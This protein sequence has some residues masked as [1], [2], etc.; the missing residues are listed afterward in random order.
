MKVFDEV[1]VKGWKEDIDSLLVFAGL[2]SAVITAFIV[3]IY[4]Q[5]QPDPAQ[6]TVQ[7]LQQISFQL[8][9]QGASLN[10]TGQ[11]VLLSNAT[12]M[13]Y[14]VRISTVWLTALVF[15][16]ISALIGI[17]AK[18]WLREYLTGMSTSPR[19]AVRLRQYRHDGLVSWHVAEII[20]CLPIL[21][22]IA[23]VLFLYGLLELLWTLDGTVAGVVTVF[24]VLSLCFYLA[25]TVVP[26]FSPNNPFKSPQSW[27]FSVSM[28]R[29]GQLWTTF[30]PV[31]DPGIITGENLGAYQPIPGNW[32]ERELKYM[33][34]EGGE[35]EQRALA[36]AYKHSLDEDFLDIV[37]PCANDLEPAAA[38]ALAVEVLTRRAE[39]SESMLMESIRS[40]SHRLVV[41][42]FIARA[43]GRGTQ[44]L[45]NMLLDVLPR[46][47]HDVE[48]AKITPLDI[49]FVLRKL[50]TTD[51]LAFCEM[52]VHRRALDTLAS[53]VDERCTEHV[54][55]AALHLLWEMTRLGCNMDYC[56]EGIVNIILCARN[57]HM[58]RD[59]DTF[60]H[61]SGI[62]LSR[63]SQTHI[64]DPRWQGREYLLDWIHN[65]EAYFQD[66][67]ESNIPY[68]LEAEAR[69]KWCSGLAVIASKNRDLLWGSLVHA[70]AE[71]ATLGL[72]DC[73]PQEGDAL[74]QL[75]G[76]YNVVAPR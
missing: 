9:P 23:L 62:L 26:A 14:T 3:E 70:L 6:L 32:R 16:M 71:G 65:L 57:A 73:G 18:Q 24:T 2:F 42:K 67:N 76:M 66:R 58:R 60:V 29:L 44:R 4:K 74:N 11:N 15:S 50:I 53:S 64:H 55:R 40:R 56:P 35:L 21:L 20:A 61:A 51:E 1:T 8:S 68:G 52:A 63:I 31:E 37:F 10:V 75:L 45:I 48:R 69:M 13:G 49:L 33:R 30:H 39:C 59:Y 34:M 27:A 36:R 5:L 47:L 38:A 22:Q 25:T 28:W 17:V 12:P 72:V 46:M 7:L 19:E 41:E 43:G 54:Q